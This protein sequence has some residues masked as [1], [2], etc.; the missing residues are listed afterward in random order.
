MSGINC[1]ANCRVS[2]TKQSQEGESLEVQESILRKFIADKGWNI[3]PKGKIW[4]TAISGRKTDRK[5]YEEIITYIKANPGKV[6]YYVFRSIDRFTRAGTGEYERMKKELIGHG[7]EMID[8]YGI[9]QPTKNTLEDLGLEYSWSKL[10]TSEITEQVMATTAKQ[11]VTNILTRMI[12]QSIRL[13]RQGYRTRRPAD[14][15]KNKRVFIDMKKKVIQEP[16]P[17][18]AKFY[19]AMFT[20]RA[21]GLSD[22]EI[23][24]RV[25]AMG[26]GSPIQDKYNVDHTKIIG[27]RGGKSLTIK[28][29]QRNIQNPIYAG[30]HCEKWTHW[31]PIR[32]QYPGL[33]DLEL[34][35]QA[36]RGK[37]TIRALPDGELELIKRD[38][39]T[40]IFRNKK[41]PLFPYKFI[42]CHICN[43]PF[44]G[45]ASR[46]KSGEK[47]PFY[48][49][50][51]NHKRLGINKETFETSIKTYIQSLKFKPEVATSLEATFLNKYREREIEI[52]QA[53]GHIHQS[54]ADLESMQ[55]EK[56]E[57]FTSTRSPV[58][59]QMLEKEIEGLELKIK[60]AGKE[61]LRIQINRADIKAFMMDAKQVMEHPAEMLL[62][63]TNTD[64]QAKLFELVFERMPTYEEVLNGTPKLS[65]VFELS[66][67]FKPDKNQWVTL[68]GVEPRFQA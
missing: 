7:V 55:T 56:L 62:N 33:V 22:P 19:I 12:G 5:D 54:I 4:K 38:S 13:T 9:I 6:Q 66:S 45:S 50:A 52:V 40:G 61:R 10:A 30:I 68:R 31:R 15:Y 18:R 37:L 28:Q 47:F 65:Y 2:S 60:K 42:R 14:G 25:N 67:N 16:D 23:V 57:A 1:V 49:C 21:R 11:E 3:E 17:T 36:N 63:P 58:L 35:N 39:K 26:Y 41:N 44:L 8:T 29:L 64:V 43:K 46:G 34:F 27:K 32:A 48:H 51:R 59:R 24:N 53:S 20:L